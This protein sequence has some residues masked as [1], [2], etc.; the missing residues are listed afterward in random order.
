MPANW[1]SYSKSE[2]ALRPLNIIVAWYLA[3]KVVVKVLK[4]KIF[5]LWV[6]NFRSLKSEFF[7]I[8]TLSSAE[9]K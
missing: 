6:L 5:N 8:E 4:D 1:N 2:T 9:N 7:I 3:H